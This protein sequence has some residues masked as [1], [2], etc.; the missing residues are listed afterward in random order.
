MLMSDSYLF[1][2]GWLFFAAWSIVL[3]VVSV[4][5]FGRDLIPSRVFIDPAQNAE[6]A[7]VDRPENL[8][9]PC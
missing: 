4:A 8:H 1:D 3:A 6:S 9:L 5:A 7:R 2:A